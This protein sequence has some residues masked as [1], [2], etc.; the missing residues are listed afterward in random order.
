MSLHANCS[1]SKRLAAQLA[2][3][4][5]TAS[6]ISKANPACHASDLRRSPYVPYVMDKSAVL[7]KAV[8]NWLSA[9]PHWTS[10]FVLIQV[11]QP[12]AGP[13]PGQGP[14]R[15]PHDPRM[16]GSDPRQQAQPR[17]VQPVQQSQPQPQGQAQPAAANLPAEQQKGKLLCDYLSLFSHIYSMLW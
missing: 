5:L 12:L 1:D 8:I 16:R 15:R 6:A 3:I 17:P 7:N 2:D 14:A 9:F 10:I 4:A 11:S 13:G